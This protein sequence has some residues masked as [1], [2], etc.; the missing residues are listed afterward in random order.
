M[1]VDTHVHAIADDL[2]KYPKVKDAY[3]W[4]SLTDKELLGSMDRLGI[5]RA[6]LVQPYFTYHYDN[7][8]Q[9]DCAKAHP[10]RFAV[11]CV[12][13]IADA[14][15]PETL[16]RLVDKDKVRGIRMF[17]GRQK[18]LLDD[19]KTYPVWEKAIALGIPITVACNLDELHK[20]PAVVANFPKAKAI[21]FEHMW[22]VKF[23]D[24]TFPE[25]RLVTALARFPN[26]YLKLCPNNSYALREVKGTAKGFYGTLIEA[27]GARRVMW[28]SNYPAHWDVYG[29]IEQRLP[30]MQEDL[31]FL[32]APDREA[33]F[34]GTAL[35][36]WPSLK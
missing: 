14:K 8:Y 30:L 6:T 5:D 26:V 1:I 24:A 10:D 28:G 17:P 18:G 20:M 29:K 31:S 11:V 7:S 32:S 34:G 4:P 35:A 13:D 15:A 16:E 25:T 27:F 22:G 12:I 36:V 23:A 33:F 21:C 19:P 3:E 9:L 2:G